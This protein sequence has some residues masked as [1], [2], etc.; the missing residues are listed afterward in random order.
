MSFMRG[1]AWLQLLAG[2]VLLAS[3]A[4]AEQKGS[5]SPL[6]VCPV[7]V[8]MWRADVSAAEILYDFAL[9]RWMGVQ[10]CRIH[11]AWELVQPKPDVW[12][13]SF[14]DWWVERARASGLEILACP[15]LPPE[16]ILSRSPGESQWQVNGTP[17]EYAEFVR[18]LVR[19][20]RGRIRHYEFWNEPIVSRPDKMDLY[21]R[22]VRAAYTAAKQEDPDVICHLGAMLGTKEPEL[23]LYRIFY[24]KIGGRFFD[25][26]DIH[27]YAVLPEQ[28][29][30]RARRIKIA[31]A[32]A[33]IDLPVWSSEVGVKIQASQG[34]SQSA[35]DAAH[36]VARLVF[37]LLA[38]ENEKVF[39]WMLRTPNSPHHGLTE[40]TGGLTPSSHAYRT[41]CHLMPTGVKLLKARFDREI[42]GAHL[43]ALERDD[44]ELVVACWGHSRRGEPPF[45]TV[46]ADVFVP[47]K[48]DSAPHYIDLLTAETAGLVQFERKTD[49]V[50]FRGVPIEPD[51]VTLISTARLEL[52]RGY[53]V[54]GDPLYPAGLLRRPE[55]KVPVALYAC[56]AAKADEKLLSDFLSW[57]KREGLTRLYVPRNARAR[58]E[59]LDIA[60]NLRIIQVDAENTPWLGT[61]EREYVYPLGVAGTKGGYANVELMRRIRKERKPVLLE[62]CDETWA[63]M[64]FPTLVVLSEDLRRLT[65]AGVPEVVARVVVNCWRVHEPS[66]AYLAQFAAGKAADPGSFLTEYCRQRYGK[67]W[68]TM[69]EFHRIQE[70]MMAQYRRPD[71][72]SRSGEA[73][74]TPMLRAE[75]DALEKLLRIAAE[76]GDTR[77]ARESVELMATVNAFARFHR[78]LR[79]KSIPVRHTVK[80]RK[81]LLARAEEAQSLLKRAK[82]INAAPERFVVIPPQAIEFY[83]KLASDLTE[84]AEAMKAPS[85]VDCFVH[86]GGMFG[87]GAPG[88]G[89]IRNIIWFVKDGEWLGNNRSGRRFVIREDENTYEVHADCD[90]AGI[91]LHQRITVCGNNVTYCLEAEAKV[92]IAANETVI[93]RSFLP[94]EFFEG[95][96]CVYRTGKKSNGLQLPARPFEKDRLLFEFTAAEFR[97]KSGGKLLIS[98]EGG[99][100]KLFANRGGRITQ[101]QLKVPAYEL[102]VYPSPHPTLKVG[103]KFSFTV[104]WQ[105]EP[106]KA[107]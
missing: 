36:A 15:N 101:G 5:P 98:I 18:R 51:R 74:R 84:R 34:E 50:L 44:G 102:I 6:G 26:V 69:R 7:H 90:R 65:E 17:E 39:Y 68:K 89:W 13:F 104:S 93:M 72:L 67:A 31:N 43:C 16:W 57:M 70:E 40:W 28:S 91:L 38:E 107:E 11:V 88:F 58:V 82:E 33:N 10:W 63:A 42:A 86:G 35:E 49:G 78:R 106:A 1:V 12:D 83:G 85:V 103:E 32:E 66:L 54:M 77:E 61:S 87:M 60:R 96:R 95:T 21:V 23:T 62:F 46:K 24:P 25:V 47:A 100:G 105:F 52:P 76:Q 81:W 41:L 75:E 59:K 4:I 3:V 99:S 80:N 37:T 20:F 2:L 73:V 27:P 30:E 79:G 64:P 53:E 22:F 14:Y 55:R 56:D 48:V 8:A 29:A 97:N 92:K 71:W 94:L 45:E 9:M 19:H